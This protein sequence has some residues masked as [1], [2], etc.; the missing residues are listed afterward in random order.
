MRFAALLAAVGFVENF[1][2]LVLGAVVVDEDDGV[3]A[4]AHGGLDFADVVPEARIAREE[5]HGPLG[6][7]AL[8][9]EGC[10]E[11]P[12]QVARR[13]HEADAGAFEVEI[14]ARPHA[15]MPGVGQDDGVRRQ[16]F[17][18]RLAYPL[19][20][21]G[22]G[23]RVQERREF[24][25]PRGAHRLN[26]REPRPAFGDFF[27]RLRQFSERDF[28]VPDDRR[29]ERVVAPEFLGVDVKLHRRDADF[30]HAPEVGGHAARLGADEKDEVGFRYQFVGA[31]P[32]IRPH[33][34]DREEVVA[35]DGFLAVHGS[36]D[37][38]LELLGEG[39]QFRVRA[40]GP[41]AAARHD[42]GP[43]RFRDDL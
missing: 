35:G 38:D 17:A 1:G 15:R 13:A 2:F 29:L 32:R 37:G 14:A 24:R 7:A 27:R 26:A 8:G 43:L 16:V 36:G 34:A 28:R 30:R 20:P 18:Q 10:G 11:P 40:R 9:P 25:P 3:D 42:D 33:H 23:V 19:G 22:G 12:A 39:D 5:D 41:D 4:P 31:P 21:H 6:R